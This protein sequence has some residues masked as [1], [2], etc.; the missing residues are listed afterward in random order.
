MSAEPLELEIVS[1]EKQLYVGHVAWVQIPGSRAP[2]MVLRNHASLVSTLSAG[3]VKWQSGGNEQ[4]I[5]VK[6]GFVEVKNNK[7]TICVE[8]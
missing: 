2:F 3:S 8:L 1:P 4:M 7:V 5:Q 6:S